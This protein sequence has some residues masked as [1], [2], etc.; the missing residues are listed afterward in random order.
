MDDVVGVD[1]VPA[2]FDGD[3]STG[4][5]FNAY[6]NLCGSIGPIYSVDTVRLFTGIKA[7]LTPSLTPNCRNSDREL[8]SETE[9][10]GP[11]ISLTET[12]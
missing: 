3:Q 5:R 8:R 1:I 6:N 7:S 11:R 10:P 2:V 9:H 4:K 12:T